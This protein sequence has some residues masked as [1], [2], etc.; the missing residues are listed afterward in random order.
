MIIRK[1]KNSDITRLLELL[2]N[3]HNLHAEG[4]PDIFQKGKQIL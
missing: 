2:Y 4:R 1:A 3:V